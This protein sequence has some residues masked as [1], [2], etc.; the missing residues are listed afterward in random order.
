MTAWF[1]TDELLEGR[2]AAAPQYARELVAGGDRAYVEK[3]LGVVEYLVPAGQLSP[4]VS[5]RDHFIRAIY[6]ILK[7]TDT[8]AAMKFAHGMR[9]SEGGT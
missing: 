1:G 5:S 4:T 2:L 9:L 7:V 8:N 6:E 3:I